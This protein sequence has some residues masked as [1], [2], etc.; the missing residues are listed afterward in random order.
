MIPRIVWGDRFNKLKESSIPEKPNNMPVVRF[1][2][3]NDSMCGIKHL[4]AWQ[5]RGVISKIQ[6]ISSSP[7]W[8][9]PTHI[10]IDLWPTSNEYNTLF[11]KYDKVREL[12]VVEYKTG[13]TSRVFGF[14]TFNKANTP[15]FNILLISNRHLKTKK[16]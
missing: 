4:K 15:V 3:Y 5:A 12:W 6:E 16:R 14:Y 9:W 11:D 13:W 8:E 10:P 7:L 2:D 1:F